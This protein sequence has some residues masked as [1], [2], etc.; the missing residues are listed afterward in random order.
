MFIFDPAQVI[1]IPS[2]HRT[3]TEAEYFQR[4]AK[5]RVIQKTKEER[6]QRLQNISHTLTKVFQF[7]DRSMF[8]KCP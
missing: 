1:H 7:A 4:L 8:V 2:T 6:A 3:E 5:E